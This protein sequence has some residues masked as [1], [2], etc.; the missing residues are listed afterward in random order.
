MRHTDNKVAK[1]LCLI[2][3]FGPLAV[4]SLRASFAVLLLQLIPVLKK[5]TATELKRITVIG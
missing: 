3:V 4:F 2:C 1:P 5:K